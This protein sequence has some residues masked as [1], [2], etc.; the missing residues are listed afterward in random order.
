MGTPLVIGQID[1]SFHAAAAAVIAELLQRAGQ[2][3][4]LTVAPHEQIYALQQ[5]GEVDLVVSAWLPASHGNYI[6]PYANDLQKLAVIYN[7]Y[8]IWGIPD[9]APAEIQSITDLSDESNSRLFRKRIQ[10]IGSGAGISRFSR[11]IIDNYELASK[12]FHFEN[13]TLKDCTDAYVDAA[14]NNELA[15]VPLW[16]PQWLHSA[17]NLRELKDP[18]GLLGGTDEATLVLRRDAIPKLADEAHRLLKSIE[19]GNETMSQLDQEICIQGLSPITAAKNWIG[20]NQ[21]LCDS[22]C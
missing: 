21:A 1:L 10:G 13:G 15:I 2:D 18:L 17:Y 4:T 5:A 3:V 22:W 9:W 12:G 20:E 7:P 6:A 19:L 16:H 8:C 14:T 11:T